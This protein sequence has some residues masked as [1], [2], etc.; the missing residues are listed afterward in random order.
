MSGNIQSLLPSKGRYR[1]AVLLLAFSVVTLALGFSIGA[2]MLSADHD[3]YLS[4]SLAS[5]IVI[6]PVLMVF[7]V[8]G[9]LLISEKLELMRNFTIFGKLKMS[10]LIVPMTIAGISVYSIGLLLSVQTVSDVGALLIALVGLLFMWFMVSGRSHGNR[11]AKVIMGAS[12]FSLALSSIAEAVRNA[13]E[14]PVVALLLLT[15]PVVYVLGERIEL[16]QMRGIGRS[17]ISFLKASSAAA[18]VLLFIDT[19]IP[20]KL[21]EFLLFNA[22]VMFLV[23][24]G[25]ISAIH[26][27]SI[28]ISGSRSILQEFMKFGIRSS[29]AWLFLGLGLYAIQYDVARG[30]MDAATHS[31]AIGFLGSF[32]ISHSPIIFPLIIK[33]RANTEKVTR[34]PLYAL[35]IAVV[36][37]V[38]GDI[39]GRFFDEGNVL[40]FS[41]IWILLLAVILFVANIARIRVPS[42]LG[43]ATLP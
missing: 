37:R 21:V 36:L 11:D 2:S 19:V 12:L 33:I 4:S 5:L 43:N 18:P 15:F 6:H 26:D 25:I 28:R 38:G 39:A 14:S 31:I 3:F 17:W 22:S 34:L 16:G 30:F 35:D 1:P 7:G 8:I 27:P 29:Y 24:M 41:S 13:V 32:I 20:G 9:G 42:H 23:S 10:L 40:V